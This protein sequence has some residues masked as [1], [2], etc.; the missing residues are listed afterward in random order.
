ML[1]GFRLI[2]TAKN[3][4]NNSWLVFWFNK[5]DELEQAIETYK[6]MY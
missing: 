3:K 6:T 5:S 4:D 2:S 1:N